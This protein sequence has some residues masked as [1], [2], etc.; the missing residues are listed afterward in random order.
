MRTRKKELLVN[1]VNLISINIAVKSIKLANLYSRILENFLLKRRVYHQTFLAI[2]VINNL[3]N[4]ISSFVNVK[5]L[6]TS[7]DNILVITIRAVFVERL[8]NK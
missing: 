7:D 5:M 2:F 6:E 4:K 1:K 3:L 8:I